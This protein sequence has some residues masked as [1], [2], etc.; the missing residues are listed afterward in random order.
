[1]IRRTVA[2]LLGWLA[3]KAAPV[4]GS[5]SGRGGF[6][7]A[8]RRRERVQQALA[9]G[10]LDGGGGRDDGEEGERED[11][12]VGL[13]LAE[14]P[15]ISGQV[16]K[17]SHGQHRRTER[18]QARYGFGDLCDLIIYSHEEG[19]QKPDPRFYA[20]ACER[21]DVRPEEIIFLDDVEVCVTAA[22]DCGLRAIRFLDN[23]QAIAAIEACLAAGDIS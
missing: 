16:R 4:S 13:N 20:L 22:R 7:D 15:E 6:V 8:A 21:L 14:E 12:A 11:V 23:A 9:L 2:N 18:E 19:M 10:A 3:R 17:D 1:M 5:A